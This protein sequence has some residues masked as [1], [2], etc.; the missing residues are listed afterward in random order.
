[1]IN[2]DVL[3]GTVE[4]TERLHEFTKKSLLNW[5]YSKSYPLCCKVSMANLSRMFGSLL[6]YLC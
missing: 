5:L 1:V 3:E 2:K 6:C 4:S